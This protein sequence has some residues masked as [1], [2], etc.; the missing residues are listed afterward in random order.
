MD[1]RNGKAGGKA[2]S[3]G[4]EGYTDRP[5]PGTAFDYPGAF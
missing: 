2:G 3:A 1:G 4:Y 5:V